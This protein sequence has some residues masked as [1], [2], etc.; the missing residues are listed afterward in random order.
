MITE[1]FHHLPGIGPGR[2]PHLFKAGI[3]T[4]KDVGLEPISIPGIGPKRWQGIHDACR[5]SEKALSEQDFPALVSLL[6]VDDHWRIIN[7]F[8]PRLS[9]FDIETTGLE[10]DAEITCISCLHKGKLH[11]FINHWNLEAF[12][13]LLE[14]VDILVSFNGNSFDVPRVLNWFHI[15]ELPCAHIDLR[16]ICHRLDYRGGLKIIEQNIGLRR[17]YDLVGVDGSQ[18]VWLWESWKRMNRRSDLE[19]L[20]RYCGADVISLEYVTAKVLESCC[21]SLPCPDPKAMWAEVNRSMSILE[22][23]FANKPTSSSKKK[24]PHRILQ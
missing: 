1:A 9:Y 8:F 5:A 4:W 18:A 6:K 2:I 11:H 13:D 10:F 14:D 15:P 16:P 21:C 17:P 3:K 19:K 7:E 24:S 23:L 20:I 22:D 12:L